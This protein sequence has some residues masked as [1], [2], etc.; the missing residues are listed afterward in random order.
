MR[1]H[2]FVLTCLAL[3]CL[4]AFGSALA[5]PLPPSVTVTLEIDAS[6]YPV[7]AESKTCVVDVPE[8]SDGKV[9]LTAATASGCIAGWSAT[10]SPTVGAF[11]LDSVDGRRAFCDTPLWLVH[12]TYW[13]LGVNGAPSSTGI[14][15]WAA[16]NGD[17]YSF[18]YDR[19]FAGLPV[20]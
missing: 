11:F 1:T 12:C 3:F 13:N 6:A 2:V 10:Y 16:A 8:G 20:P 17:S 14:D 5:P 7:L 18:T 9:M 15:G 4:P 19:S